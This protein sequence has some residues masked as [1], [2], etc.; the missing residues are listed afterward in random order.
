[1]AKRKPAAAKSTAK[2]TDGLSNARR[3]LLALSAA[4]E[5]DA[6]ARAARAQISEIG[7]NGNLAL[8]IHLSAIFDRM[9][10]VSEALMDVA[11]PGE[12]VAAELEEVLHFAP[13]P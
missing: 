7:T 3:V 11:Q 10:V 1:M 8:E 2:P 13:A 5:I 12:G 6:L 4:W 9:I